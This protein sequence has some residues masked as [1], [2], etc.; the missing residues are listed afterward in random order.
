MNNVLITGANG[1]LGSELREICRNDDNFQFFFT[2]VDE[3]DITNKQ[4]IDDFLEKNKIQFVV[5]CAA[6]TQVDRAEDDEERA[7]LINHIAVK[8]LAE[9][10]KKYDA[11]FLHISTDYVFSGKNNIPYS[12][13]FEAEP[14]GV[15]GLTKLDGEKAI[16]NSS[17]K[18]IIIRT[19]WLYSSFGSNF[20]KTISRLVKEKEE[21]KVIFDQVGTPT[22]AYDLAEMILTILKSKD[23]FKKQGVYHFSNEGVC[24]WYDFAVQIRNLVGAKCE[25]IPCHSDEFPAKVKRPN[26]SVLDKTKIKETF[27]YKIPYWLDSLRTCMDKI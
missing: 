8:Y 6:Y 26:F 5:N 21:L 13:C 11:F 1:Q 14:I 23:Y 27:N 15:Y 20:V 22:Y 2:D 4:N 7:D 3:L 19:S 24:S 12:E 9:S 10:C 18:Y 16:E 17:C 25:I